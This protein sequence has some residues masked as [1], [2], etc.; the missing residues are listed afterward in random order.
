MRHHAQTI[1]GPDLDESNSPATPDSC[2]AP[3][4]SAALASRVA[5]A[6]REDKQ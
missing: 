3:C 6:E 4:L 2:P 1:V 5:R